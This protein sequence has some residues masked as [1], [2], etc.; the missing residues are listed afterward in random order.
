MFVRRGDSFP[1]LLFLFLP[2]LFFLLRF[3][4]EQP[5]SALLHPLTRY[6]KRSSECKKPR[7]PTP[8]RPRLSL[9]H[10]GLRRDTVAQMLNLQLN[11]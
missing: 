4:V 10:C 6:H 2:L 7:W 1:L 3:P 9:R 11:F 8:S 5:P